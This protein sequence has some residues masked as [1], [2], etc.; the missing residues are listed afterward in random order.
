MAKRLFFFLVVLIGLDLTSSAAAT[1]TELPKE[2][3]LD[4]KKMPAVWQTEDPHLRGFFAGMKDFATSLDEA[5]EIQRRPD[6]DG[7][8]GSVKVEFERRIA[9]LE[10]LVENNVVGLRIAL[11]ADLKKVLR[12]EAG[13][14]EI[15]FA[16]GRTCRDAG[17]TIKDDETFTC[18]HGILLKRPAT[19]KPVFVVLF[20]PRE[21]LSPKGYPRGEWVTSVI[22]APPKRNGG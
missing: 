1:A 18:G 12:I 6:Y 7:A 20:V 21:Y 9:M 22:L 10:S 4:G 13:D 16:D 2:W 3:K 17:L 11:Y 5:R 8:P 15:T 14:L 19:L